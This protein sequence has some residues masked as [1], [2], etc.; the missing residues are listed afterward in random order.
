MDNTWGTRGSKRERMIPL[1]VASALFM[2]LMDGAAVATALPSMA[3]A[4]GRNVVDLR[5]V[6]TAYVLTIAVLVPASAWLSARF[7]IRRLFMTA[8]IV[9]G[10]G[11]VTC[12]LAQSLTQLVVARILQGAGGAMMTPVGRSLVVRSVPRGALVHAM[13]LFTLPAI[14]APMIGPP[15][16]GLLVEAFSWRWIFLINL[17]VCVIGVIAVRLFAPA[18]ADDVPER[19]DFIGFALLAIGMVALSAL[20]D[21]GD[22]SAGGMI[23]RLALAGAV[24]GA[25]F[26]YRHHARRVAAPILDPLLLRAPTLRV[27]LW[28]GGLQRLAVGGLPFLLPLLLQQSLHMSPLDAGKVMIASA[29][30]GLAARFFVPW[31]LERLDIRAMMAACALGASLGTVALAAVDRTTPVWVIATCLAIVGVVRSGFFIP[32]TAIAYVDLD[33]RAVGQATVLLTMAQQF[34]ISVGVSLSAVLLHAPVWSG[35]SPA[36]A[37][38]ALAFAGIGLASSLALVWIA[39]LPTA[40]GDALRAAK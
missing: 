5:T 25:W 40:A 39:R 26:A 9:F 35:A 20:V 28:A 34:S 11:S 21:A 24:A 18:L 13:T 23:V 4:F 37:N 3:R 32:A 14:I 30:G 8:M 1:V 29:T 22:L 16:S 38:F 10:I 33:P 7:G 15:L 31:L 12:A 2:H 6:I 19:F 36:A 27:S 17:P